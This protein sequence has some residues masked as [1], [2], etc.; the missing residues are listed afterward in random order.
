MS[1]PK[2]YKESNSQEPN[3]MYICFLNIH[4]ELLLSFFILLSAL[5]IKFIINECGNALK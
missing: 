4:G 1:V 3:P 5:L 2:S